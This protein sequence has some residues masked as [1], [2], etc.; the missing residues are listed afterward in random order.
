LSKTIGSGDQL[1]DQS[2]VAYC[3]SGNFGAV[4]ELATT[5]KQWG[6]QLQALVGLIGCQWAV[7]IESATQLVARRQRLARAADDVASNEPSPSAVPTCAMLPI[8]S[9][10]PYFG[11][12]GFSPKLLICP[13]WLQSTSELDAVRSHYLQSIPLNPQESML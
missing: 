1:I 4:L 8:P 12:H 11:A 6:W 5:L 9:S 13:L 3:R 7:A 10:T 2:Y